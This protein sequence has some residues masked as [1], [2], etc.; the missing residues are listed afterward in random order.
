MEMREVL[1]FPVLYYYLMRSAE[2]Y[3]SLNQIADELIDDG[4]EIKIVK[5]PRKNGPKKQIM[6]KGNYRY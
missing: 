1:F 3:S 2:Y 5:L 4:K 6:F